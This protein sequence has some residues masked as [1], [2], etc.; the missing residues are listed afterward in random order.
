MADLALYPLEHRYRLANQQNENSNVD[1]IF[2]PACYY[3]TLG[4]VT[5]ISRWSECSLQRLVRSAQLSNELQ[6][7]VIVTGG[8]FLHDK[9]V[10]YA[11]KAK[12]F[13]LSLNIAAERIIVIGEGTNTAEEIKNIRGFVKDKNVL[14]VTSATH[15]KR[16]K[17]LL[18][19]HRATVVFATVDFHS[20]GDLTPYLKTPSVDAILRIQKALYEYGASIKQI[21]NG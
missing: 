8:N 12:Q 20:S 19:Q 11:E 3:F 18:E 17:A 15:V 13:L 7:P 9:S 10:N 21:I 5:E 6:A 4:K 14:L 2:T 16:C 1:V